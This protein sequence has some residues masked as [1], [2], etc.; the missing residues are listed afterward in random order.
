MV[1]Q[2]NVSLRT[3]NIQ[4]IYIYTYSVYI[5]ACL[6][7][8]IGH[9]ALDGVFWNYSTSIILKSVKGCE[10]GEDTPVSLT[11]LRRLNQHFC[12]QMCGFP[13]SKQLLNARWVSDAN[14]D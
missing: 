5:C 10:N 7:K 9:T 1:R 12:Y 4:Y 14:W 2:L 6:Y 11:V 13:Q 3:N 8:H